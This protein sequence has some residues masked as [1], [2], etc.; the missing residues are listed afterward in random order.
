MFPYVISISITDS[1]GSDK[2]LFRTDS[3]NRI[4]Y[5]S[6]GMTPVIWLSDNIHYFLFR[7]FTFFT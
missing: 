1:T 2:Q 6:A 7:F 4:P 3:Y 5:F